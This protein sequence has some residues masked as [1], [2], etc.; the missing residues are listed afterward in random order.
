LVPRLGKPL[1]GEF[2]KWR[3]K[4]KKNL[5]FLKMEITWKILKIENKDQI[6]E[7]LLTVQNV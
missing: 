3:I 6:L 2:E 1:K 7:I 4:I 5:K